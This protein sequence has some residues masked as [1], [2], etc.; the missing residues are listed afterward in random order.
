MGVKSY[1]SSYRV[2]APQAPKR[3]QAAPQKFNFF[4]KWTNLQGLLILNYDRAGHHVAYPTCTTLLT[5]LAPTFLGIRG[6]CASY[7]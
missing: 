2:W 4:Q 6:H 7:S 5:L 1:I 3:T